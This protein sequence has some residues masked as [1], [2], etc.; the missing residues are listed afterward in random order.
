M[1]MK[2]LTEAD[3]VCNS[4]KDE[5][6]AKMA[7]VSQGAGYKDLLSD[8]I[9]EALIRLNEPSITLVCRQQDLGTVQAVAKPAAD[10]FVAAAKASGLEHMAACAKG[11][12]VSVSTDNFLPAGPEKVA[13]PDLPSCLGGIVALNGNNTISCSNTLDARLDIAFEEQLP[14]I[15]AKLFGNMTIC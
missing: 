15:R 4:L 11:C 7:D 6:K 3:A 5:A 10:K 1:R 12:N 2:V 8:L 13:S 14:V 9:V